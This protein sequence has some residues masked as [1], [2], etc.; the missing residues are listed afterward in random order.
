MLP[1]VCDRLNRRGRILRPAGQAS[2]AK[3][4]QEIR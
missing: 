4:N 2:T 1:E 3:Q